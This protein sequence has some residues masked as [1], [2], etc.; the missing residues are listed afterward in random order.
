MKKVIISIIILILIVIAYLMIFKSFSLGNF[1][2]QN[3]K[4]IQALD[5][6]LNQ[7]IA[8]ANKKTS[9]EYRA[10]I[11]T[12]KTSIEDM[13]KA[14][15]KYEEYKVQSESGLI[16]VK[17]YKVE[18]LWA[19]IGQYAKKRNT[20]LT[21]DLIETTGENLYDLNFTLIGDYSDIINCISD[22]ED[23]DTFDFKITN[24]T[25]E[26]YRKN[27]QKV[28]TQYNE[29]YT[30][31]ITINEGTNETVITEQI[32]AYDGIETI[33]ETDNKT[34]ATSYDPKRLISTFKIENVGIQFN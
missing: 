32:S 29:E 21:L 5:E 18:Y 4:G 28:E 2:I 22:I 31:S 20:Q 30:E 34:Q 10:E 24:F 27:Y 14:K 23:D 12:L 25:M 13:V 19:I 15:Q 8:T 26:P 9:Q 3:V 6:K 17:T 16:E 1:S 11:E 7:E 33:E